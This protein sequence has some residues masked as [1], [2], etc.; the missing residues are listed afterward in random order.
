VESYLERY[1]KKRTDLDLFRP[2]LTVR[3]LAEGKLN[4]FD[5]TKKAHNFAALLFK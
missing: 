1:N 3:R 2:V 4:S 5:K